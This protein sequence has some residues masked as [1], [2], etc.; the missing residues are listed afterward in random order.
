MSAREP[1]Q[2][3][4]ISTAPA[5]RGIS[6]YELSRRSVRSQ[7]DLSNSSDIHRSVLLSPT[8]SPR[9]RHG[10]RLSHRSSE[11]VEDKGKKLPQSSPTARLPHLFR[12]SPTLP[13]LITRCHSRNSL[14]S[15]RAVP[16]HHRTDSHP[17]H[18]AFPGEL[19][20]HGYDCPLA[21]HYFPLGYR[22]PPRY[23]IA[24]TLS[25]TRHRSPLPPIH[26]HLAEYAPPPQSHYHSEGYYPPSPPFSTYIY[27]QREDAYHRP[28]QSPRPRPHIHSHTHPMS[29]ECDVRF[30]SAD[31]LGHGSRLS[32]GL[33]LIP[34]NGPSGGTVDKNTS[35]QASMVSTGKL[36]FSGIKLARKRANDVQLAALSDAF[37]RTHYPST[38]ERHELAMQLGMTSRSVQIWFQ[39]RRRADKVDQESAIQ[40]A[41]AKARAAEAT[42]RELPAPPFLVGG[43]SGGSGS[44]RNGGAKLENNIEVDVVVK[45]ER[46]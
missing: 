36:A 21:D 26:V 39:N 42:R 31:R 40:R 7:E 38:K 9:S 34:V 27:S 5:L 33:R 25:S 16:I 1:S 18:Q 8:A 45:R 3:A 14:P 30:H 35:S 23:S 28:S 4:K 13:P 24:Q 41:E 20:E 44:R 15:T 32:Y 19:R 46:Q 10:P 22:S 29:T 12:F 43:M 17:I 37:R 2:K 6:I 11:V